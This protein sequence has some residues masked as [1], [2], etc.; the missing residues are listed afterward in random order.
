MVKKVNETG[1]VFPRSPMDYGQ[2]MKPRFDPNLDEASKAFKP[3]R[4]YTWISGTDPAYAEGPFATRAEA[5]KVA[6]EQDVE[7]SGGSGKLF[8]KTHVMMGSDLQSLKDVWNNGPKKSIGEATSDEDKS[9]YENDPRWTE[10]NKLIAQQQFTAAKELMN[11]IRY[12]HHMDESISEDKEA[13]YSGYNHIKPKSTDKEVPMSHKLKKGEC[14]R[15]QYVMPN[16]KK[17]SIKVCGDHDGQTAQQLVD[18]YLEDHPDCKDFHVF[19]IATKTNEDVKWKNFHRWYDSSPKDVVRKAR[20]A[21]TNFLKNVVSV[22]PRDIGG[23]AKLQWMAAKKELE[24]RGESFGESVDEAISDEAWEQKPIDQAAIKRQSD[25]VQY[26]NSKLHGMGWKVKVDGLI[27]R[28]IRGS[29]LLRVEFDIDNPNQLTYDIGSIGT[30]GREFSDETG[31]GPVDKNVAKM[32]IKSAKFL[33]ENMTTN[34][35]S[36]REGV[37]NDE[38]NPEADIVICMDKDG[39]K[40][41]FKGINSEGRYFWTKNKKHARSFESSHSAH[42]VV[43][44]IKEHDPFVYPMG[45]I[46]KNHGEAPYHMQ[47]ED[48]FEEVEECND[49]GIDSPF[50]DIDLDESQDIPH[51]EIV[52]RANGRDGVER[53]IR[54]EPNSLGMSDHGIYHKMPDG[55]YKHIDTYSSLD[56]AKNVLRNEVDESVDEDWSAD[57]YNHQKF[58]DA[59]AERG[60][61]AIAKPGHKEFIPTMDEAGGDDHYNGEDVVLQDLSGMF[62]GMDN[63]RN[64]GLDEDSAFDNAPEPKDIA[65]ALFMKYKGQPIDKALI[66]KEWLATK[67]NWS[68]R[69]MIKP[70]YSNILQL[71]SHFAKNPGEVYDLD[72]D[73]Y[74]QDD[75]NEPN[76]SAMDADPDSVIDEY[77]DTM[78]S[79]GI[80][81]LP[82]HEDFNDA[83]LFVG[84]TVFYVDEDRNKKR[85]KVVK[86]SEKYPGY[87]VVKSDD[88][89]RGDLIKPFEILKVIDEDINEAM[90]DEVSAPGQEAWIKANK[91]RFVKEYGKKKGLRILYSTAWN[92]SKGKGKNNESIEEASSAISGNP[93]ING[94]FERDADDIKKYQ[95]SGEL[96]DRLFNDVYSY[97]QNKGCVPGDVDSGKVNPY[98]WVSNQLDKMLN[99]DQGWHDAEEKEDT[100][101]GY[102]ESDKDMQHFE[103]MFSE[104]METKKTTGNNMSK[105]KLTES[106]DFAEGDTKKILD[107]LGSMLKNAGLASQYP[108]MTEVNVNDLNQVNEDSSVKSWTVGIEYG[109]T[110]A[111][112]KEFT[113]KAKTSE[114][115]KKK[116][117]SEANKAGLKNVMV[118]A[119]SLNED[120]TAT[121]TM[122]KTEPTCSTTLTISDQ[123]GD[124]LD[125]LLSLS[126][127]KKEEPM[128]PEMGMH[129]MEPAE[130]T[131]VV[132]SDGGM[133]M[134]ESLEEDDDTYSYDNTPEEDV[135]S[136]D[137]QMNRGSDQHR[138]KNQFSKEYPGDN[139]MAVESVEGWEAKF[140]KLVDESSNQVSEDLKSD[141]QAMADKMKKK[142]T[143]SEKKPESKSA[144]SKEELQAQLK[145]LEAKFDPQFE[146]SDDHAFWSK[147]KAIKDR[148]ADIKKQLKSA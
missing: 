22:D 36:L 139:H 69:F 123:C 62:N 124:E 137:S 113:V 96:T 109:P 8:K 114:E 146:R 79:K 148:I 93:G 117:K 25:F 136:M 95:E 41:F 98:K 87:L 141:M 118:N 78:Q 45:F 85:G 12:A 33:D 16:G 111:D 52:H 11:R 15:A 131:A 44:M 108:K 35:K 5:E 17:E 27:F 91:A 138:P 80:E 47:V 61:V 4:F 63:V 83:A 31:N 13:S 10:Y 30:Q 70:D 75:V 14:L 7:V 65:K 140:K 133:G 144:K 59:P 119:P 26:L 48:Y 40:L 94:T 46:G 60:N 97:F 128:Q 92:R 77:Y 127:F 34:K 143:S 43:K 147:Q 142:P 89:G 121:L 18:K 106:F 72:D 86:V 132:V 107:S 58:V 1:D 74:L 2:G 49:N 88:S 135:Y 9:A 53:V 42:S 104:S 99:S 21:D 20:E 103:S 19:K 66:K 67:P 105:K 84:K 115:A 76:T 64:E 112:C 29:E 32:L 110:G 82:V 126:G 6:R 122:T 56:R 134:E 39:G 71:Y 81:K 55:K 125:K 102:D 145:S 101:Y 116:A 38:H 68:T 120:V 3:N 23:A 51:H 130:P 57:E 73:K 54:R 129:T 100:D 90:V 50:S 28:W 24:R 37:Y